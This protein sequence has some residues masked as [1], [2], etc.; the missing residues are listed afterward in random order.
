MELCGKILFF[1]IGC[2]EHDDIDKELQRM[3]V[4]VKGKKN[5]IILKANKNTFQTIMILAENVQIDFTIRN[6]IRTVLRLDSKIY[7]KGRHAS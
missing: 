5:D 7:K 6:L 1:S 3:V 2:Y 4:V